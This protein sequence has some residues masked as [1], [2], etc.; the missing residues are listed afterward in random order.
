MKMMSKEIAFLLLVAFAGLLLGCASE[1]MVQKAVP[2][3]SV[4]AVPETKKNTSSNP[5]IN[6]I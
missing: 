5:V 6:W 3:S 2:A 1:P 4:P